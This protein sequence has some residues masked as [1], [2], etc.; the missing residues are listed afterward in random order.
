MH[1][2]KSTVVLKYT[3]FIHFAKRIVV[4]NVSM[5]NKILSAAVFLKAQLLDKTEN[6]NPLYVCLF[7]LLL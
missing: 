7:A 1:S 3:I 6:I 5:Q 4:K 2:H